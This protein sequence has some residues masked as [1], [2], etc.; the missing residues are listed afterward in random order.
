MCR[1]KRVQKQKVDTD[2]TATAVLPFDAELSRTC[3]D[4]GIVD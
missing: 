1:Y 2:M 4:L 3:N